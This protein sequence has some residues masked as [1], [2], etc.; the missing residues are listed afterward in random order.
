M[1]LRNEEECHVERKAQRSGDEWGVEAV[2]SGAQGVA[3]C[4]VPWEL[5]P[6]CSQLV[7]VL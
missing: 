5:Y 7:I 6:Q 1:I 4:R 2:G 3:H